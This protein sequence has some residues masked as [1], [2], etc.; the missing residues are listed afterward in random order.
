MQVYASHHGLSK[1]AGHLVEDEGFDCQFTGGKLYGSHQFLNWWQQYATGILHLDGFE[2]QSEANKKRHPNGWRFLLAENKDEG[3]EPIKCEC[4]V[5][6]RLPP[7]ST[8]AT[9]F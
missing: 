4:P 9:P 3:F 1:A 6:I 8:A 2:S 7:V 5:D